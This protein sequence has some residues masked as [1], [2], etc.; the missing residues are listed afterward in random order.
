[1]L[2]PGVGRWTAAVA[3]AVAFGDPDAIAVGDFHLKNVVAWS[4]RGQARGTDEEMLEVLEPYA[5]QRGRVVRWLQIDGHR[6]PA[7]G[8]RKPIIPITQL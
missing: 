2:I 4:L 8:P 1:M 6:A 3:G 7:R 5:G